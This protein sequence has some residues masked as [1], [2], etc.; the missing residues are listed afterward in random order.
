MR[1]DQEKSNYYIKQG[2]EPS[3]RFVVP[4]AKLYVREQG[5]RSGPIPNMVLSNPPSTCRRVT[6]GFI[7]FSFVPIRLRLVPK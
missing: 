5:G 1:E 6:V 2:S 4:E 3:L 7:D